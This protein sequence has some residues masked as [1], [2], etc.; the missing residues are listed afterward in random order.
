MSV[1]EEL[2]VQYITNDEGQRSAVVIPIEQFNQL[3]EDLADLAVIAERR[4]EPTISHAELK[5][6]LSG[7]QRT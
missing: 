3:L 5:T 1:I 6:M 7:R 2:K 4:D